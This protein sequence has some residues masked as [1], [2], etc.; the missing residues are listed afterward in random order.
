MASKLIDSD[1]LGVG[2]MLDLAR[3]MVERNEPF[4]GSVIF[5][6]SIRIAVRVKLTLQSGT[7]PK[8]SYRGHPKHIS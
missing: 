5:G 2:V 4:N 8:V 6:M 3:V 7:V 1:G